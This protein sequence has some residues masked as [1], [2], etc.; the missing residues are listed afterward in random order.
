MDQPPRLE[1]QL[2]IKTSEIVN[3]SNSTR[4]VYK[5]PRKKTKYVRKDKTFQKLND[6]LRTMEKHGGGAPQ[7]TK[8]NANPEKQDINPFYTLP[9][10]V[11]KA[12]IFSRTDWSSRGISKRFS[13]TS[14]R[15]VGMRLREGYWTGFFNGEKFTRDIPYPDNI[16]KIELL[17]FK[18]ENLVIIPITKCIKLTSLKIVCKDVNDLSPIG[19]LNNLQSLDLNLITVKGL[20]KSFPTLESL[21]LHGSVNVIPDCP[22]LKRVHLD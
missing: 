11:F 16:T 4:I 3:I 15:S 2:P 6:V 5:F 7:N 9:D 17:L 14:S 13:N 19:E 22:M 12:E 10:D 21:V 20:P 1:V 8:T 18:V